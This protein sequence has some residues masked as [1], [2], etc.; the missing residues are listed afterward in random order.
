M[1]EE[2]V[3]AELFV[4]HPLPPSGWTYTLATRLGHMLRIAEKRYGERDPAYTILGVEFTDGSPQIWYPGNDAKVAIQL[5][6]QCLSEPLR[7][8][9]QLAHECIHLLS[10]SGD[11]HVTVLEEGLATHFSS[12]YMWEQFGSVW[13]PGLQSY[14]DAESLVRSLLELDPNAVRTLREREPHIGK[15]GADVVLERYPGVGAEAARRL[16]SPFIRGE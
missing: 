7:A 3:A 11:R 9:Y 2:T 13:T 5:N 8:Y 16:A 10:P 1:G 6:S 12:A 14:T 15:I 4:A